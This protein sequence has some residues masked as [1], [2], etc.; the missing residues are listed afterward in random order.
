[1]F[2]CYWCLNR[3]RIRVDNQGGKKNMTGP[4]QSLIVK[5]KQILFDLNYLLLVFCTQMIQFSFIVIL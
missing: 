3:I 2:D 4:K 5:E 1:M